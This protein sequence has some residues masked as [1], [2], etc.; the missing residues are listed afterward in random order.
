MLIKLGT[1]YITS[2]SILIHHRQRKYPHTLAN[3]ITQ[4]KKLI[5]QNREEKNK[6]KKS[7]LINL[8]IS[9]CLS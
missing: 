2:K 5:K 8:I 4:K 9:F 3:L 7:Y 1:K 6:K